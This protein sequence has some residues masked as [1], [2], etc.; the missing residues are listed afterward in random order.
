MLIKHVCGQCFAKA[1]AEG[2]V[3]EAAPAIEADEEA[4]EQAKADG[5]CDHPTLCPSCFA[6]C[7]YS[8]NIPY[9]IHLQI[10]FFVSCM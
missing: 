4:D 8:S 9:A 2:A 10:F 3:A 5:V 6:L 7:V 1:A